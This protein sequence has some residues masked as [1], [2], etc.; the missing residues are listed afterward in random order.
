MQVAYKLS[1]LQCTLN[2]LCYIL[3]AIHFMG[4]YNVKAGVA[5]KL[6]PI[7]GLFK[8]LA[9]LLAALPTKTCAHPCQSMHKLGS[10]G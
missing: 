10:A 3:C 6:W 4:L 9:F 5:L 8:E 2:K 1:Q 7:R